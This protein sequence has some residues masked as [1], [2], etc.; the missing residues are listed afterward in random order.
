MK[1]DYLSAGE[2]KRAIDEML[3]NEENLRRK[4]NSLMSLEVYKGRQ[5][6][7]VLDKIRQEMGVDQ[8]ING[9]TI[10]SINLTRKIIKEKSSL[11]K[12]NPDREFTNVND[13]QD[14]HIRKLYDMAMANVKLKKSNEIYKL[15]EQSLLQVVLKEG[16]LEL[17]PLY[18]HHFDVIP[19]ADNPEKM[20]AVIISS[21]DKWRLFSQNTTGAVGTSPTSRVNYYADYN[22]QTIADPDDYRNK[23]LFYWWTRDFNFI[24]NATGKLVDASG[25]PL[26]EVADP[27]DPS[28][29]SPIAG[30]MPFIDVAT[31]KDF[32]FYV[33]SGY[34]STVFSIDLNALLSDT[35]EIARMQGWSQAIISSVEEPRDMKIGPR[36]AMWLKIN[37]N[38]GDTARPS[39]QFASP[40]PDL[41]S[42]LQLI[43]NFLSL[44]LTSEGLSPSVVNSSG[45][46]DQATSGLDRWLK[47]LE[48]FEAT[49]DDVSL[50][51]GV[52]DKLFEIIKAWNNTYANVT[53]NGF[54]PELS[55]VLIPEDAKVDVKFHKPQML[56]G[57]GEKLDVISRK[58]EMGLISQLEAIEVDRG[59]SRERAEEIVEEIRQDEMGEVVNAEA[60]SVG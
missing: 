39:F 46:T 1:M 49:Q 50:Y 13:A 45:K 56:M 52:E 33:R 9:R 20:D 55:G 30:T 58:L 60:E 8:I 48:K 18:Q 27:N 17:R 59:V 14:E 43:E 19:D 24:T 3:N 23:G 21:F 22:N 40:N 57:E 41:A 54:I 53:E 32:E 5:R 38:D 35:S 42:S 10:T 51:E 29:R 36:R 28:V 44:Y 34:S 11:Y 37:P 7:F 6:P 26:P 4:E 12:T 47:M 16:V 15:Q 31:D 25:N 2:R